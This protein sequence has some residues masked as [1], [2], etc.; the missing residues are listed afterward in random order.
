MDEKSR[1]RKPEW[2]RIKLPTTDDYS[3]I[4]EILTEN[5]LHTI[6]ESGKCPNI[7]ECWKNKTATFM[8]LGDICTRSC[9]FCNV[10]TGKPLAPDSNQPIKLARTISKLK[11][12]HCVITSV[13]R[14]DLPDHGAA[15]WAETIK[16]I[17]ELN[18][19]TTIET[20]I[21]DLD[22]NPELLDI[23]IAAKPDIISHNM[24]TVRRL[25]PKI[26]TKATYEKSLSVIK[27]LAQQD[28]KAK[29][30]FMVGLGETD[31]EIEEILN[32]L[33]KNSCKIVTI[34][35]YLQPSKNNHAVEKYYTPEEFEKI[36]SFASGLFEIVE[37][38]PLVRSSYHAEKH[39]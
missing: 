29:S 37:C 26:R 21:P 31:D 20:L 8:I 17:K 30:G 10:T 5:D 1:L 16:Q 24:E 6:C 4:K 35:Q 27:Y 36:K 11:L 19:A 14:D 38:G 15:F 25:T 9:K 22:A 7:A 39:I 32:D 23:V 34:G 13:T 18:P 12:S 2:L 28:V 33:S 3:Y